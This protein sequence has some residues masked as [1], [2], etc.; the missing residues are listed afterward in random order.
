MEEEEE[1]EEDDDEEE[2]GAASVTGRTLFTT[3]TAVSDVAD[4]IR[5][6]GRA[7]RMHTM[8]STAATA[9]PLD[10]EDWP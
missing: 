10:P 1:E 3:V 2:E 5:P 8:W 9:I 7:N 4:S 6:S